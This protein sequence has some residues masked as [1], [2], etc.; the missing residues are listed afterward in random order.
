MSASCIFCKIVHGEIPCEKI[1]EDGDLIAFK[2]IHPAAPVHYLIVPKVHI[3]TLNDVST[4]KTSLLGKM[5]TTASEL[6]KKAGIHEDGYRTII[7]CNKNAG[8]V[9]FHLHMHLLGGR[10]LRSMG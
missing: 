8:Q 3:P 9:V 7:N 6:A 5:L 1:F 2:D 4:D 10:D